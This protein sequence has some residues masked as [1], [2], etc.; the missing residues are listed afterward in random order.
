MFQQTGP[1]FRELIRRMLFL[2]QVEEAQQL[3]LVNFRRWKAS[4]MLEAGASLSEVVESG[5]WAPG[6]LG[7]AVASC[8]DESVFD[9]AAVLNVV[10]AETGDA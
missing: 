3:T 4:A 8:L 9:A 2:L 10:A 7:E 5:E 6:F 1:S